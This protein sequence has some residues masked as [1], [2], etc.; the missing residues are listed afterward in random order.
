M[1]KNYSSNNPLLD[2]SYVDAKLWAKTRSLFPEE[3]EKRL[4]GETV[5]IPD[6]ELDFS[7][8]Q[9]RQHYG[10]GELRKEY[11]REV[12]CSRVVVA[13]VGAISCMLLIAM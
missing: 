5:D 12:S 3:V 1:W 9:S 2:P 13:M 7:Y 11:E 4:Q 8:V 6:K 10:Q